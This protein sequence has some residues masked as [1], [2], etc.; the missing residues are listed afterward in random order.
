MRYNNSSDVIKAIS[1]AANR[2]SYNEAAFV[3]DGF[4]N[5]DFSEVFNS[6]TDADTIGFINCTFYNCKIKSNIM[7]INEAI[8]IKFFDCSFDNCIIMP[9]DSIVTVYRAYI[10]NSC[11]FLFS[12]LIKKRK[13]KSFRE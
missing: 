6:N 12:I 7:P 10:V 4:E 8:F 11:Y 1:N 5:I 3:S 2:P 13:L 9:I